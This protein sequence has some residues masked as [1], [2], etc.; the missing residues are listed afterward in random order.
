VAALLA[1]AAVRPSLQAWR[2]SWSWGAALLGA[3][4]GLAWVL[5]TSGDGGAAAAE[6]AAMSPG[7]RWAWLA[8]RI[9]GSTLLIPL[10][11]ELAFRGWLLP[12]LAS[13]TSAQAGPA[14]SWPAAALS[15]LAFGALHQHWALGAL[16]GVAFAVALRRR[17]RLGDAVLAHATCNGVIAVAAAWLGRWDLWT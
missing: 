15:S 3:G 4:V 9:L 13:P 14:W 16:A 8:V 2:P 7:A 10:V 6:L 5:L 1:L 12:W 17:G 11:E